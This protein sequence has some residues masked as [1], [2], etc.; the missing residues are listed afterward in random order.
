MEKTLQ[1]RL[2]AIDQAEKR[3]AAIEQAQARLATIEQAQTRL[4]KAESKVKGPNTY[5]ATGLRPAKSNVEKIWDV[6]SP[7]TVQGGSLRTWSFANPNVDFVQVLLKTEGR[8]LNADIDLWQG[9]DNTPYKMKVYVEDGGSRTFSAVI[10]TPR[11]PNTV[12]IRNTGQ[13]EFPLS[14]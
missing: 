6:S 13:L 7:I 14:A 11:S 4:S 5:E 1:T 2:A 10:G 8:P 9:P 12:A 3:L